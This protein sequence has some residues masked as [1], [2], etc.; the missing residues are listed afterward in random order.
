MA[1]LVA[2]ASKHGATKQI[3]ERVGADLADR[4]FKVEVKN[5]QDVD[6]LDRYEAVVLGSAIYFG[7]WMK[8]A[9]RFVDAHANDLAS[10]PTWLFGSGPIVGNPPVADDPNAIR[11]SLV[12]KLVSSTHAREHKLFGGRSKGARSAWPRGCP[13]GWCA[14]ARATGA[15][16][17]PSTN[18]QR[19]SRTSSRSADDARRG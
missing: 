18:G 16:G 1:V 13:C 4:G 6:R 8:E 17:R 10:R 15:T 5:L 7:K 2:A 3:A 12:E 9:L 14:R 11:P 19:R